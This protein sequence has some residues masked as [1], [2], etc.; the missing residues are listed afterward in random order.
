MLLR[1]GLI[2]GT[3]MTVTGATMPENLSAWPDLEPGNEVIRPLS[4]PLRKLDIFSFGVEILLPRAV[5]PRSLA[6]KAQFSRES[7]GASIANSI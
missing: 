3:I 1:A 4:E 2:D 7:Q 5:W 6:M